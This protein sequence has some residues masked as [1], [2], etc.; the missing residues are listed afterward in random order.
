[1]MKRNKIYSLTSKATLVPFHW[2]L[3]I[4]SNMSR[5]STREPTEKLVGNE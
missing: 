4:R 1:M 5:Y 3:E 2:H